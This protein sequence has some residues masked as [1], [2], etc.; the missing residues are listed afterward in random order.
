MLLAI[1]PVRQKST[2]IELFPK[3]SREH[4]WIKDGVEIHFQNKE[5][6]DACIFCSNKIMNQRELQEHFSQDFLNL[7]KG[8]ND[9]TIYISTALTE[10]EGK[11]GFKREKMMIKSAFN[12]I[13]NLITKKRKDLSTEQILSDFV[14][15]FKEEN[16]YLLDEIRENP[17]WK[18]ETHFVARSYRDYIS[19][20]RMFKD[21]EDKQKG[22]HIS[23][24]ENRGRN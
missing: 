7:D 6:Y 19:K 10:I 9:I 13:E 20:Q 1:K 16:K 12:D 18:I 11:I 14:S 5:P 4:K 21:C 2:R 23:N 15:C 3:D 22:D 17:A 8:L 24:Q